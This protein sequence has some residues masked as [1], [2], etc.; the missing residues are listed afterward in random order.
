MPLVPICRKLK[1]SGQIS[2]QG[3]TPL[4]VAVIY[5]SFDVVSILFKDKL[6]I[7]LKKVMKAA[8]ENEESGKEVMTLL[9]EQREGR[10]DHYRRGGE[11]SGRE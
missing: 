9:L 7:I 10:C 6:T 1:E 8:A 2:D 4:E 5:G 11:G 3:R